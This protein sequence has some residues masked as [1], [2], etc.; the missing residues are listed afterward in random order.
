MET[1]SFHCTSCRQ[2]LKIA[3]DKAGRKV[4]CVKC[5]TVLTVPVSDRSE[6]TTQAYVPAPEASEQE[7]EAEQEPRNS[8][9]TAD[10]DR[11]KRKKKKRSR[12]TVSDDPAWGRVRLGLLLL[13]LVVAVTAVTATGNLVS[14]WV[15]SIYLYQIAFV[16]LAV[17]LGVAG[18]TLLLNL[19]GYG[20]CLS[21]PDQPARR[22]ALVMVIATVV[23]GAAEFLILW[24]TA[25][26]TPKMPDDFA[27]VNP[28]E[29]QKT[30]AQ[31]TA[32]LRWLTVLSVPLH[33]VQYAPL[34]VV[35]LFL[36][37][38]AQAV[39]A[40]ELDQ[41]CNQLLKINI[42]LVVLS[43]LMSLLGTFFLT[44]RMF[45]AVPIGALTGVLHIVQAVWFV[46]IA[47]QLRRAIAARND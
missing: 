6:S 13:V 7:P 21:A 30:L 24:A 1:V 44:A 34:V 15:L 20:L 27:H 8:A 43:I 37:R 36:R 23:S 38:L 22:L 12:P 4:K 33:I 9:D 14:G 3:A 17:S 25:A 39:G 45:V 10:A 41:S 18:I 31:T 42:A 47:I 26:F 2:L 35:P 46:M 11:P 28:Q 16:M 19:A 5:G 40:G 29:I 32:F